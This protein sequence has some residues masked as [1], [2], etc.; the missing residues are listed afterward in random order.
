MITEIAIEDVGICRPLNMWQV[1][2]IKR[3][4]NRENKAIAVV[5]FGFGMTVQQFKTLTPEKQSACR[6]ASLRLSAPDNCR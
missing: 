2:R 1:E 4:A 5:A 6:A 3:M